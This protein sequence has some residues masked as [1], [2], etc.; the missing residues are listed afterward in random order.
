MVPDAEDEGPRRWAYSDKPPLAGVE[1]GAIL[2]RLILVRPRLFTSFELQVSSY[3][4]CSRFLMSC[5]GERLTNDKG[6]L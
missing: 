6:L 2:D 5:C 1:S 3:V 4:G